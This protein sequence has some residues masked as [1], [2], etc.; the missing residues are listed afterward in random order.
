VLLEK[1][2]PFFIYKTM[3]ALLEQIKD[4][5]NNKF[6]NDFT[7]EANDVDKNNKLQLM[8][9]FSLIEEALHKP[10]AIINSVAKDYSK[11][12]LNI[13]FKKL[14]EAELG[15]KLDIEMRFY[16]ID[17]KTVELKAFIR[18]ISKNGKVKKVAKTS[19]VYKAVHINKKAA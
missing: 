18:T 1:E 3:R 2:A 12:I 6:V 4:T 16:G 17:N 14:A 7:V 19:Y 5:T 9:L 10:K 8:A 11:E 15:E 13:D